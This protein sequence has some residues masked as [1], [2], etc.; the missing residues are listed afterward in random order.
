MFCLV[1]LCTTNEL[2]A[3]KGQKRG[4]DPLDPELQMAVTRVFM[5]LSGII[6]L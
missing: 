1:C 6:T 2:G 4:L 5:M 3:Y